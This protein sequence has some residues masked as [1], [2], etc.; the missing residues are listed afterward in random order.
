MNRGKR[1]VRPGPW[2]KEPYGPLPDTTI[3]HK[4]RGGRKKRMAQ[5]NAIPLPDFDDAD[6]NEVLVT[7]SEFTGNFISFYNVDPNKVIVTL[8]Y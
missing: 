1:D 8:V 4:R 6:D 5:P 2:Q 7:H 3:V